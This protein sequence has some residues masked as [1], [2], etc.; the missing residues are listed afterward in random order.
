M[1]IIV[2]I[3]S[4][5]NPKGVNAATKSIT[6]FDGITKKLGG[7]LAPVF[8]AK[9]VVSFFAASV[10]GAREDQKA[11]VQLERSIRNTTNA[12]SAQIAGLSSFIRETQF[13]TGVLDDQLR[14][15]LNR[16]VLA[17][18]DVEKSQKLLSL[19]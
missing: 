18:G 12:T 13:S 8:A 4:Q 5:W 6:S 15:A 3:V 17:T 11:Q 10:R 19:V 1:A 14:P 2:P 16:L 7:T 9:Q